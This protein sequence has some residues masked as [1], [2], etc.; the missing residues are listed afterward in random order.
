M[1]GGLI[2]TEHALSAVERYD[3]LRDTWESLPNLNTG[4]REHSSCILGSTMYVLG[5]YDKYYR[6]DVQ[7]LN[8]IEKLV[9][10]DGPA[11][12]FSQWDLIQ[13]D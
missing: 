6:D 1:S 2:A 7:Y 3:S 8:S 10:I 5:G 4:R 12:F 9:N 11:Q 13:L